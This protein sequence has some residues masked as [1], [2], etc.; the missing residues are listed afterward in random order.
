MVCPRLEIFTPL[1]AVLVNCYH[2]YHFIPQTNG[3]I[4]QVVET[5]Q[6]SI[7]LSLPG[8]APVIWLLINTTKVNFNCSLVKYDVP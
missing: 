6:V 1:S 3:A 8:V 7:S 4:R 5:K 2:G